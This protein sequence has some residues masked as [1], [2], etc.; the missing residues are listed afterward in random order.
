LDAF[1]DKVVEGGN[2]HRQEERGHDN[3]VK[4]FLEDLYWL[5]REALPFED[6]SRQQMDGNVH[7]VGLVEH[8]DEF[9]EARH[10][11]RVFVDVLAGN[12]LAIVAPFKHQ[13]RHFTD[14]HKYIYFDN[15]IIL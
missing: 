10:F 15:S 7:F 8:S 13:L 3:V 14:H 5:F 12:V 4:Y 11:A 2:V 6:Q 9:D 1:A